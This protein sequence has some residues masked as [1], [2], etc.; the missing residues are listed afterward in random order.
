MIQLI[1]VTE[2]NWMSIARLSVTDRQKTFL[3]SPLGIIAR[4]YV[5]RHCNA[6]VIGIADGSQIIG[7]ALVRDLDEEPACYDLQQF[8]IDKSFQNKG[9]G[10]EALKLIIKMLKN[11]GK[12]DCVEVCVNKEATPALKVYEKI[13]FVDTGYIDDDAPDCLNLM[14][15]FR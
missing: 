14:Y 12:Y 1:E 7:V 15:Y 3:D 4:G 13:G 10:T 2:E 9:Y 11:E 8:M 5:Y 6:R